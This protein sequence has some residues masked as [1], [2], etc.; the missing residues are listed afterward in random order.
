MLRPV[1][2]QPAAREDE[3]L[4]RTPRHTTVEPMS[5][6]LAREWESLADRVQAPPFLRA[7]WVQAWWRAF[8]RGTMSAWCVR[9]GDGRLVALLPVRSSGGRV[10]STTNH[11][12]PMYG[13]LAED[14]SALAELGAHVF[15]APSRSVTL[16]LLAAG[17]D[18]GGLEAAAVAAGR[19]T[20]RREQGQL[21]FVTLDGTPP[22][23]RL[24]AS[25][26]ADL[27]RCRRRLHEQGRVKVD[28][29]TAA[30][31]LDQTLDE[32]LT[33]EAMGWKGQRGVA[34]A[35][36]PTTAAFYRE[37]ARWA[38]REGLLR[39]SILR[40]DERPIAVSFALAAHGEVYL[41]KGGF[42]P[43]QRRCSPGRLLLGDL[44]ADASR[45]G[46]RC[47]HLLGAPE[48]YKVEWAD[49]FER[50]C[51]L[52]AFAR[53]RTGAVEWGAFAWGRPLARRVRDRGQ[54]AIGRHNPPR[55]RGG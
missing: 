9:S 13:P 46:M 14:P 3:P 49:G 27:R 41:L 42:D 21:P 24:P 35:S 6:G 2:N 50:R 51:V 7:G 25:R 45:A 48:P 16:L 20:L 4:S 23:E 12:T 47:A 36:R 5:A 8:G 10:T 54:G 53:T 18:V 15:G 32:I 19:R 43:S 37:V 28:L 34:V 55:A 33:V 52:Q 39:I 30:T 22:E 29:I 1:L 44:L 26:R 17:P 38:A 40:L 11:H 31:G